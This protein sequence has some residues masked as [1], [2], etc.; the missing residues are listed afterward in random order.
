MNKIR[1]LWRRYGRAVVAVLTAAG[2]LLASALTDGRV[3][4]GEALQVAIQTT[5]AASV[6][7]APNLP[8]SVGI[9]TGFAAVLAVLNLATSLIVDGLT[10]GEVVNLVLA[11]VG[12]LAVGVAPSQS[13]AQTYVPRSVAAA[14]GQPPDGR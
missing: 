5:T 8:Y 7:L 12:V 9:K 2:V 11:G 13:A 10:T 4:Q 1:E 3:D 6:W 14:M